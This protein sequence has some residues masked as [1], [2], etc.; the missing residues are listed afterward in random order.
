MTR[1]KHS[2]HQERSPWKTVS[3]DLRHFHCTELIAAVHRT[4]DQLVLFPTPSSDPNDP[5]NWSSARKILNFTLVSFFVLWTFVQL[6]IGF[7]RN[8]SH[9]EHHYTNI[10]RRHGVQW[11]QNSDFQW[12]F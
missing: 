8:H 6:D 2:G 1:M 7:V 4:Q 11:R 5:L 12:T 9:I 3:E 10:H